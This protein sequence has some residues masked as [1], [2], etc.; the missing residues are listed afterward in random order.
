MT[1]PEKRTIPQGNSAPIDST[2]VP[3]AGILGL[4]QICGQSEV[5]SSLKL[6]ADL[7]KK[8]GETPEH[9]LLTGADG[10]G[11]QTIARAFA[12][13]YCA[14]LHQ[15]ESKELKR[16]YDLSALVTL[17]EPGEA[18]VLLNLQDL[19]VQVCE[20]LATALN[21][22]Q[23]PLTIGIGPGARI[24]PFHLS[25]FTCIATAPI[26]SALSPELLKCFSLRLAL[27]MYSEDE[28]KPLVVLVANQNG[29]ALTPE[30]IDQVVRLCEGKPNRITMLLRRLARLGEKQITLQESTEL[31]SAFGLV[32]PTVDLTGPPRNLDALSGIEFERMVTTLLVKMGFRAEMTKASGDGGI[33]IIANLEKPIIGGRYL[34]QCKRFD[35]ETQIGAP[36]IREFYGALV[37]DGKALKG[38][39]VTTSR[40]TTQARDFAHSLPLELI[41]GQ[42]L[43]TLLEQYQ[44]RST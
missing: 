26:E 17:L 31:L 25:R 5:V 6:F 12:K 13:N 40:F 35:T 34:I 21:E 41:D 18:L 14:V 4:E 44:D 32:S 36:M 28:L 23:F 16:P 27:K 19:K 20:L 22:F 43:Q 10:M 7:F 15:S 42:Q 24:H 38:I 9:I 37:A 2:V 8:K 39:F 3:M 11:K 30:V 1:P 33:D 29:L